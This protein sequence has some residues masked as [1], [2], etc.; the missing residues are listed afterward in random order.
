MIYYLVFVAVAGNVMTT[1]NYSNT[2]DDRMHEYDK[3]FC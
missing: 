2:N 3:D 1:M